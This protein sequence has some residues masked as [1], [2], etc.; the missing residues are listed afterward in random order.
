[1]KRLVLLILLFA[2]APQTVTLA[3]PPADYTIETPLIPPATQ[4]PAQFTPEIQT[5]A[6]ASCTDT[7][8]NNTHTAGVVVS[9]KIL[10]DECLNTKIDDEL[11]SLGQVV[12]YTC[13]NDEPVANIHACTY[14]CQ[15]G[16]CQL[17]LASPTLLVRNA[18]CTGQNIPGLTVTKCFNSCLGNSQCIPQ[19]YVGKN[20]LLPAQLNCLTRNDAW[21]INRWIDFSITRPMNVTFF[22]HILASEL[23]FVEIRDTAGNLLAT[24]IEKRPTATNRCFVRA[25]GTDTALLPPGNYTVVIGARATGTDLF[26][27]FRG[28][29]FGISEAGARP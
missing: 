15:R 17:E 2:C 16:A 27:S 21:D 11:I 6:P 3:P 23:A 5:P 18:T 14:G 25:L 28:L 13:Q 8:G 22:A 1:M 4:T 26:R 29:H 20:V 12:E 7:D 19:S 24:P 9:E 10:R